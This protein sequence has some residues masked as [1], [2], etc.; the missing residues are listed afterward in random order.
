MSV[1]HPFGDLGAA[2]VARPFCMEFIN[3]GGSSNRMC[4][5][6]ITSD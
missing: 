1:V 2:F 3:P 4:Y 5:T 6:G